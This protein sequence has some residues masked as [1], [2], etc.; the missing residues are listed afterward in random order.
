MNT[1]LLQSAF[2]VV[3]LALCIGGWQAWSFYDGEFRKNERKIKDLNAELVKVK[4]ARRI[5]EEALKRGR[6]QANY[7][8]RFNFL[9]E[10]G[11]KM[12]DV[13]PQALKIITPWFEANKLNFVKF[14]ILPVESAHKM[15]RYPFNIVGFGNFKAIDLTMRWLEEDLRAVITDFRVSA[16]HPDKSE[17]RKDAN[18]SGLYFNISWYWL[19]GAPE[20]LHSIIKEGDKAPVLKR[21]PFKRYRP[22]VKTRKKKKGPAEIV[23][24]PAPDTLELQ[25]IM[26][27]G[28]VY[29][30]MINGKYLVAGQ[31]VNDYR[32]LSVRPTEVVVARKN[33]RSRLS[34]K[35]FH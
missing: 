32:V 23:W 2:V 7:N 29:K 22:V 6:G 31:T 27:A 15:K 4:E 12:E 11:I 8:V 30:A 21:D 35:L 28:G 3:F 20:R 26:S 19:E 18:P 5:W 13:G 17:Y 14:D 9:T 34:L 1:R 24:R 10:Q 25:G 33:V 16:E